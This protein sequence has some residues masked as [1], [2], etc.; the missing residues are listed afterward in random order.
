M[1]SLSQTINRQ[2]DQQASYPGGAQA[3]NQFIMK[4]QK[5]PETCIENGI[6]GRVYVKFVVEADGSITS[7]AVIRSVH[8][9]LDA[10]AIRLILSMPKWIPARCGDR[11]C[12]SSITLPLN[13]AMV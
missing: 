12:R 3:L 13:F 7:V 4:E 1:D 10:E 11:T 2:A 5:Y 6:Q 8:P 9:L